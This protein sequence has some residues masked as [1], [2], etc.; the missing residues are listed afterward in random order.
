[1][2]RLL[3]LTAVLVLTAAACSGSTDT[4]DEA[5]SADTSPPDTAATA[6]PAA[7]TG[8]QWLFVLDATG[9]TSSTDGDTTTLTLTGVEDD[10]VA[11]T[12]RPDREVS[13]ETPGEFVE[14]WDE[15]GFADVA[16]NAALDLGN[17]D[18][19]VVEITD[20]TWDADTSTL[21]VAATVL[22][23][24]T[25]ASG[26]TATTGDL[27]ASFGAVSLF[28]DAAGSPSLPTIVSFEYTGAGSPEVM[29]DQDL[30]P[31]SRDW[32]IDVGVEGG[33]AG[34]MIRPLEG[35]TITMSAEDGTSTVSVEAAL[36]PAADGTVTGF[37]AELGEGGTMEIR[38]LQPQ[39]STVTVTADD[40]EF[41]L[42]PNS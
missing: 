26:H 22:D 17:D 12:D 14:R 30:A 10:V 27:P 41:T 31:A 25:T 40:P 11:F 1:M 29:V 20:P 21:T 15:R 2:R 7:A 3:V 36:M 32:V 37:A 42:T 6:D 19:V 39:G 38:M 8:P 9:G 5:G 4:T 24:D 34:V 35:T 13:T 33:D 23:P 18:I 16:P 28:V